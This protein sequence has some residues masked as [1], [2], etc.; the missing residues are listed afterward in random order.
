M[1]EWQSLCLYIFIP[2][3]PH[4]LLLTVQI[5]EIFKSLMNLCVGGSKSSFVPGTVWKI[6]LLNGLVTIYRQ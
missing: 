6:D 4:I 5:I 3:L 1:V 2:N